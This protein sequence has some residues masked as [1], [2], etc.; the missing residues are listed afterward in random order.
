MLHV[1]GSN[2][3]RRVS[4][5]SIAAAVA[6]AAMPVWAGPDEA[7]EER[8]MQAQALFDDGQRVAETDP[9]SALGAFRAAYDT[10]PDYHVL[11]NIGRLC[12]RLSDT[13]GASR[14]FEQYLREGGE[15][16]PAKRRKEVEA[17]LKLLGKNVGALTIKSNVKD[18]DVRIDGVVV[19]RTPLG[20]A[21]FVSGGVHRIALGA[22]GSAVEKSVR[23]G[24]GGEKSV[25]FDGGKEEP[26]PAASAAPILVAPEP[27]APATVTPAVAERAPSAPQANRKG[28]SF[29]TVP[30]LVTG[31]FAAGA[32]ASGIFT[33]NANDAY[34]SIRNAYP[35]TQEELE[36]AH[37]KARNLLM[38]TGILGAATV[39]SLGVAGYFTFFRSA[40]P[41][42]KTV[43][44]AIGPAGISIR[45]KLP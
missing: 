31:A 14:A 9:K 42:E 24:A 17:Q 1:C 43:G 37:G 25:D 44:I 4:S 16:I 27:V 5:I 36:L 45:G 8:R 7:G 30:W 34:E 20:H 22:D 15:K 38:V 32:V 12:V 35:I 2:F 26:A 28:R 18:V 11:Y 19:G 13:L 39:V 41:T 21:V 29:P 33:M 6:L 10:Q 40:P 23:I 3:C